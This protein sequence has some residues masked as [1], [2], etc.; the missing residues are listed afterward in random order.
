MKEWPPADFGFSTFSKGKPET[1]PPADF[2]FSTFSK[3]K[4]ETWPSVALR[5]HVQRGGFALILTT[6]FG[7]GAI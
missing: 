7:A 6:K 2:G 4:P 1:R 3:G 5:L